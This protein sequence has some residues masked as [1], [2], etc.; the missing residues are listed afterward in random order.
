MQ[1]GDFETFFRA[2]ERRI[3][4]QIHRLGIT[5]AWYDDFYSEGII[6]LWE[7]YK[8]YDA[9]KGN[10]GTFINYKIRFRLIDLLRKKL[11]RQELLAKAIAEEKIALENG[12]RHR[13]SKLPIV[14]PTGIEIRDDA[15]WQEVRKRLTEKQWKWVKYYII[16]DLTVKE[17]MEIEGVTADTVK[18]WGREVR[19]KLRNEPVWQWLE[20][21]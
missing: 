19:R 1:K 2:N 3:H 5:D 8:E 6:A 18:G 16:A 17:I 4:Y 10:L 9:E 11:R 13:P 21:M 15:F 12:N 20:K 14:D 7:A